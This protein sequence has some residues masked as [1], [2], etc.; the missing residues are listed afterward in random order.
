MTT[1]TDQRWQSF[2]LC[3]LVELPLA[4]LC[5]WLSYHTHQIAELRIRLLL[6]Q[7]QR[8][9]LRLHLRSRRR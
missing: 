4:A 3:G 1:P 2:V 5:L 8:L 9:R 6:R 7:R